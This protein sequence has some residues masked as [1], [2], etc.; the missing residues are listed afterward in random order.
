MAGEAAWGLM[1]GPPALLS[2]RRQQPL[3]LGLPGP[4]VEMGTRGPRRPLCR[5]KASA[6][7]DGVRRKLVF[8]PRCLR[9]VVGVEVEDKRTSIETLPRVL[10]QLG[11]QEALA[12]NHTRTRSVSHHHAGL[13]LLCSS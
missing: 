11:V 7:R 13:A 4:C 5:W 6:R 1:I 12:P 9:S 8:C 10:T 3:F 2:R